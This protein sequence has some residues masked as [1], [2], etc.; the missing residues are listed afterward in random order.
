L[1]ISTTRLSLALGISA[2]EAF[3]FEVELDFLPGLAQL[4]QFGPAPA[5]LGDA[6]GLAQNLPDRRL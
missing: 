4:Q 2:D 1:A 5:I 6:T 3:I